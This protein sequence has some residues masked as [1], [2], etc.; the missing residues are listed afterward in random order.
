[1]KKTM[2][3]FVIGAIFICAGTDNVIAQKAEGQV[4]ISAGVGYWMYS[5]SQQGRIAPLVGLGL[6]QD[7]NTYSQPVLNGMID[8]GVADFFSMGIA[9]SHQKMEV[10]WENH[11]YYADTIWKV[12]DVTEEF[13]RLNIG[14]RPLVHF[15][16][17]DNID[18]YTG[19]RMSYS[20]WTYD[21]DSEDPN[22]DD[23]NLERTRMNIQLL[24][25]LRAYFSDVIGMH[26]EIGMG[27]PCVAAMGLSFKLG[28]SAKKQSP[29]M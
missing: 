4:V 2:F 29:S 12:E 28:N 26:M 10:E 14:I 1:M 13:T 3:L 17:H 15:I 6:I 23:R 19:L 25:G 7:N 21:H 27:A 20:L 22:W 9:V 8:Y 18:M 24:I 11:Q 16:K 5:T